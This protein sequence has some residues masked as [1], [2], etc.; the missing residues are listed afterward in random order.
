MP[1]FAVRAMA[2]LFVAATM[3][4][5]PV[6]QAYASEAAEID[7]AVDEGLQKLFAEIPEA[8]EL[9]EKSAG[10]LVFPRI[11][12]AGL[13][14]G[15]AGGK[16]ALRIDGKTAGYY[17]SRAV[18]YGYQA[19]I[20]TFGYALFLVG[21]EDLKSLQE[22]RGDFA[23]GTSPSLVIADKGFVKALGTGTL[24]NGIVAFFFSEE[25]LMVGA[26]LQ[27]TKVT[28]INP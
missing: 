6:P 25:G 7:A 16:G 5:V 4:T 12:K 3:L 22:N 14:A 1:N 8:R 17:Q 21:E 18:S 2:A 10:V 26:G 24:R 11:V 28:Q 20:E 15:F 9:A 27:A 23:V 13:V 19:G